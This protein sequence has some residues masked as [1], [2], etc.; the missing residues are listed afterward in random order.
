MNKTSPRSLQEDD[1]INEGQAG[2]RNVWVIRGKVF[3]HD[4][5]VVVVRE[6][7]TCNKTKLSGANFLFYWARQF[8]IIKGRKAAAA[9]AGDVSSADLCSHLTSTPL[10][11]SPLYFL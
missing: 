2:P 8:S 4:G 9:A 6:G 3:H 10:H 1:E 11:T 7:E 5:V